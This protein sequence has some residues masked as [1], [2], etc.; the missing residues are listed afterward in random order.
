ME[1]CGVWA[2]T[3]GSA[4]ADFRAA[5]GKGCNDRF[6]VKRSTSQGVDVLEARIWPC[7]MAM[8]EVSGISQ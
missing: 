6:Q 7:A 1:E 2:E 5:P 4:W 8:H 3:L